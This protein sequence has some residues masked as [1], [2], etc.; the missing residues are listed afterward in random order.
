MAPTTG[1]GRFTPWNLVVTQDDDLPTLYLHDAVGQTWSDED[2]NTSQVWATALDQ[3]TS[4]R[5]RVR[6][7]SGGG[8][9]WDGIAIY[10]LLTSHP[11]TVEVIIDGMAA[12][13]ASVV[14]MAGDTVTMLTGAQMMIHDASGLCWGNAADMRKTAEALDVCSD[15]TAAIYARHAG[16]TAAEWRQ[17]MTAETWLT[18]DQ[19]IEL[20]LADRV[21]KAEAAPA[22]MA[23]PRYVPAAG[24][25]GVAHTSRTTKL[26]AAEP[27]DM[28]H[29][30]RKTI[31]D[32]LMGALV[33]RLGLDSDAAPATV[34][35][36]LDERLTATMTTPPQGTVLVDAAQWQAVQAGAALGAQAQAQ[37]DA[38]RR[39][40][41]VDQAVRDGRIATV[42][43]DAFLAMLDAD[44]AR[45]VALLDTL[46]PNTVPVT[47]IGYTAAAGDVSAEAARD[48]ELRRKM[49]GGK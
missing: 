30:E 46:A 21:D 39:T 20:G 40:G 28:T 33:A 44:E 12:S 18:A 36:A 43:R 32:E 14:A 2:D 8:S 41:I 35:A 37:L 9:A 7:N 3:I 27:V 25:T 34:L 49:D 6:I 31:M 23:V 5:V 17:R 19:A 42:S 13:A 4:D 38:Q 22:A 45:T 16:G 11:A 1:P 29:D 26:P 48:A 15:S 10:N 47:E 24:Q